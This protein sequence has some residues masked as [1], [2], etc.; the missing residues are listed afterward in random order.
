MPIL[1]SPG[2]PEQAGEARGA[3]SASI[4]NDTTV[5]NKFLSLILAGGWL[6][7]LLI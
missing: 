6:A 5:P 3:D 7:A 2:E 1:Q 4:F